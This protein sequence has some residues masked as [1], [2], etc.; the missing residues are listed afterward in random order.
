MLNG[1]KPEIKMGGDF[2]VIPMDKYTVQI[3]DVN[4]EEVTKWQSVEKEEVL[5]YK[6]VILD[7][8]TIENEDGGTSSTRGRFLWHKIRLVYGKTS[9]LAKLATAVVGRDLTK[10]EVAKLDV[11]SLV[12]KQV[13]VITE[14]KD[15]K[16]GTRTFTNIKVFTKTKKELE[17]LGDVSKGA[18]VHKE[19][20][21]VT[22]PT[23]VKKDADEFLGNL[24][25]EGEVSEGGL[26]PAGQVLDELSEEEELERQEAA[27]AAKRKALAAKKAASK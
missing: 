1:V 25:K 22:A 12:G 19:S 13:D 10:E 21:P 7:D 18:V 4:L 27:L 3:V 17:P 26:K 8:K 14:N 6:F 16:D 2:D 24:K 9:W 11:E 20:V 15:S 5:N 23:A